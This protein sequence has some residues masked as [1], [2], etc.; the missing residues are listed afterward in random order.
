MK[1]Y[2]ELVAAGENERARMD[3]VS[4]AV[5]AHK[6]SEDYR[7]ARDAQLYYAKRNAT[8]SRYQEMFYDVNGRQVV[9]LSEQYYKLTH[10]FFRRFVLQ[11]VQ[12]VLSNGVTFGDKAK[13]R[14]GA[15]FDARLSALAKKAMVDGVGFG[16]WNYDHLEVFGLADTRREPGFAPLYDEE[17]GALRAGVRFWRVMGA[18]ASRYTLY[19]EDGTTEYIQRD[20]AEMAVLAEK[21]PYIQVTVSSES[22]GVESVQGMNYPGFPILPMYANDMRES[23]IVG[24]RPAIDCYDFIK[25]GMANDVGKAAKIYWTLKNVGGMD[26]MD[27]Q[28]FLDRMRVVKAAVLEDGTEAEAHTLSVP[29]EANERLLDRLRADLYEDFMLLDTEKALSGNMTATAIRLAYQP[30]EDKCGDFEFHIR[31]FIARLLALLGIEDEPSFRWNRIANQSEETQMVMA[32]ASELGTELTL[33][34]L[35]FLTPEEVEQRMK[36]LAAEDLAR[37]AAVEDM[38][39]NGA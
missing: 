15:D 32:A 37:L 34:K 29:V 35:P 12:Y 11:Q 8:M 39:E 22:G 13:D 18:N 31:D 17:N 10:G 36:E 23:E 3:F 4:L 16:F 1:T 24:I 19:E 30:Q 25:S 5:E 28:R 7:V 20:G 33:K 2:Q 14:L 26:D 21:R 27:L 9:N 6:A 38:T